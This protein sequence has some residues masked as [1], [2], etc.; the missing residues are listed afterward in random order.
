MGINDN[1][2]L[3]A[4][5]IP[6]KEAYL[7]KLLLSN[8]TYYVYCLYKRK[9]ISRSFNS[10]PVK[11][12]HRIEKKAQTYP[13]TYFNPHLNLIIFPLYCKDPN[14]NVEIVYILAPAL[15]TLNAHWKDVESKH[16]NTICKDDSKMCS[17][18][19]HGLNWMPSI[20]RVL[21]TICRN[22]G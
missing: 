12:T 6:Y 2:V 9:I 22:Y 20:Y 16:I 14:P 10:I 7:T 21:Q 11:I 5:Y 19:R 13:P 8:I 18:L 4:L 15:L 3:T 1:L 17:L